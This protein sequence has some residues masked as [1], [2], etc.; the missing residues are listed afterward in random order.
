[1]SAITNSSSHFEKLK[2]KRGESRIEKVTKDREEP[3]GLNKRAR[4][5]AAGQMDVTRPDGTQGK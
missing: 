5:I 4:R 1:M 2:T 3:F